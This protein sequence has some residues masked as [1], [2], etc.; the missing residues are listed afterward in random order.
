VYRA[1]ADG[2]HI[3][4]IT[5]D[6]G[7][8]YGPQWS[9]DG[10]WITMLADYTIHGTIYMMRPDGSDIRKVTNSINAERGPM[11]MP[12]FEVTWHPG[13]LILGILCASLMFTI[14]NVLVAM[15]INRLE[16]AQFH[17]KRNMV[18]NRPVLCLCHTLGKIT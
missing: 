17:T 7:S 8:E 15:V 18:F 9:P 1:N 13:A 5:D 16:T 2:S 12:P 14:T 4:R 3:T 10:R 11:W 6:P